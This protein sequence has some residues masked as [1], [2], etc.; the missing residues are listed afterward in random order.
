MSKLGIHVASDKRTGFGDLLKAGAPLVVSVDQN[1]IAECHAA[2]AFVAFRTQKSSMGEDNPPGLIDAPASQVSSLAAQWMVSLKPIYDLNSGADCYIVN[3]ELDIVT[4]DSAIN[5]SL[6]YLRCMELADLWRIKIGICS[7]SSGNPTDDG[8]FTLE[9]RWL[10][11]VPAIKYAQDHGHYIVLHAHQLTNVSMIKNGEDESLR[12]QR[13]LRYFASQNLYP[14]V[15]I[16][17]LSNGVGGVEP[18]LDEYM[19]NVQWWDQ[20]VM[21]SVWRDQVIGGALYGF[22]AAETIRTAVPNLVQWI[23]AHPTPVDVPPPVGVGDPRVDYART[24]NVLYEGTSEADDVAVFLEAR[25]KRQTVGWSYDDAMIGKLTSR[26]ANLWNVPIDKRASFLAFRDQYYPGVVVNF[27]SQSVTPQPST[28]PALRGLQMR[29]DGGSGPLDFQCLVDGGLNA[30]KIMSNTS[31]EEFDKLCTM[32]GGKNI[33]LRMFAAPDNPVLGNAAQ[34]FDQHK[35]WLGHFAAKGGLY[36]EVHNEPNLVEEGFGRWWSNADSFGAFYASV[37]EMIHMN[38]PTLKVGY[39]GLSPNTSN[40]QT[41]ID[42]IKRLILVN[43]VDWIGAHSYWINAYDMDVEA[44]GRH[45]RR[46]LNFGKPVLITEFA[47]VGM[48]DIDF[49][50]GTQYKAYYASLEPSVIGAF[51]FVSS[52]SKFEFNTIRQTWVRNGALTDIV[53]GV[54]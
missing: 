6:F 27:K 18:T 23:E 21:N 35:L 15:I 52:A 53:R 4:M 3:N 9:Q 51:A 2:G 36:V 5:L 25:K 37:A 10:P 24:V 43:K 20:Q 12:H 50:K 39:P 45:Y 11:L 54:A 26:T 32:V 17:E 47:N 14:K 48:V 44:N 8:G 31:F 30:A 1:V 38:Y 40:E 29:A 19:L 13:T 34:F 41:F 33:V 42:S 28:S 49:E 22:N 46:F 16:G 7:F